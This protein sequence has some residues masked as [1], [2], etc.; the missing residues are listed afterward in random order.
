M[1]LW[2]SG[3]RVRP[4]AVDGQFY[5]GDPVRLAGMVDAYVA[6]APMAPL[7]GELRAVIVPHAGHIYS[8]PVAGYA[9]RLLGQALDPPIERVVLMGPSHFVPV[10][11]IA[12]SSAS[13][14]RTP[15]GEIH[16]DTEGLADLRATLPESVTVDDDVHRHEH[17]LEVQLPFLQRV[18]R[19]TTWRLLPLAVGHVGAHT[20]SDVIEH[21]A[22]SDGAAS[23]VFVI[24]TDLSHYEDHATATRLDATTAG[25]VVDLREGRIGDRDACGAYALRGM[26]LASQHLGWD[27]TLLDLR[28]SGD[29]AGPR[30]RVVGYGAF[31]VT[32]PLPAE[33]QQ[34]SRGSASTAAD[35]SAES[36]SG[37]ALTNELKSDLLRLARQT[38]EVSLRTGAP[39]DPPVDPP[40]GMREPAATFVTLRRRSTG[41]LLGCIGALE[42]RKPLA[43][44]VVE[45]SHAAAFR[46][47]RFPPL[48]E[49]VF[50]DT[51]IDISVLGPME[52]FPVDGYDDLAAR[53]PQGR[54]LLVRDGLR[55]AT[56]LP[57]V[58]EQLPDP[59]VFLASLWR[60]AGLQQG[61]WSD[62]TQVWTYEVTEFAEA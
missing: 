30:D 62:G 31:A 9:Y 24:S 39:P 59:A 42:A 34:E 33:Q 32:G 51:V 44:D 25:A 20:A 11:A 60:K 17:C 28:N 2:G 57:S 46:D 54:G 58:W 40:T 16:L 37:H 41:E 61:H 18:L 7:K 36:D 4:P 29:T 14:W 8:G 35:D 38:I 56:Y 3:K 27:I 1:R 48:S 21:L 45:H 6:Q 19:D 12:G 5:D 53:L 50:A 15:L 26:M 10:T 43:D 23:T 22:A 13:S 55:Q 47:P 49:D 52:P